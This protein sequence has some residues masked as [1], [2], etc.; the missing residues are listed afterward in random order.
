MSRRGTGTSPSHRPPCPRTGHCRLHARPRGGVVPC[1]RRAAILHLSARERMPSRS[2]G[3]VSVS[4]ILVRGPARDEGLL[5]LASS[6]QNRQDRSPWTASQSNAPGACPHCG[7]R[8]AG[9]PAAVCRIRAAHR[10]TAHS[11]PGR[12]QPDPSGPGATGGSGGTAWRAANGIPRRPPPTDWKAGSAAQ[13]P[14]PPDAGVEARG[15]NP[16]LRVPDDPRHGLNQGRKPACAEDANDG[17]EPV[18]TGW[19]RCRTGQFHIR[20]ATGI[21]TPVGDFAQG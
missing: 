11:G 5:P 18:S 14:D 2:I 8:P 19:K 4:L 1:N 20:P 10:G 13:V 15:G 17:P 16:R 3:K 7:A 21:V 12:G 6:C 9:G